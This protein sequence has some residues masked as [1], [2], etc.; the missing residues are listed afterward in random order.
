MKISTILFIIMSTLI[1]A[2][3]VHNYITNPASRI[4]LNQ[5]DVKRMQKNYDYL[6]E[7]ITK[8]IG[9]PNDID[10]VSTT[11][12]Y[13]SAFYSY[14]NADSNLVNKVI[15]N[16]EA[17]P[18]WQEIDP[19]TEGD[20]DKFKKYCNKEKTLAISTPNSKNKNTLTIYVY[21]F[22]ESYCQLRMFDDQK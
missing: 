13:V 7:D 10:R 1:I 19:S 5:E 3:N 4:K 20:N 12:G 9:K 22:R 18:E 17:Q 14:A 2:F 21:W 6:M 15:R 8:D 11:T 16:I